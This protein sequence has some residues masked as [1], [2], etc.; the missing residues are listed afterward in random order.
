MTC[1]QDQK[2]TLSDFQDTVEVVCPGCGK[3][4][5]AKADQEKK[6]ARLYCLECGYAKTAGTEMEILR[7]KGHFIDA[8]HV[9]FQA[10]LWYAAPFKNEIFWAYNREHLV[11][12]ESY[13]AA[14]LREHKYRLHF[15]LLEKLPRFYHEAKNREA[16]LKVIARLKKRGK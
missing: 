16:L 6:E 9:Y 3:K 13:I 10:D 7:M 2:H 8:A 11:Y 1:F 4:A 5:T 12:L 14:T 15:T